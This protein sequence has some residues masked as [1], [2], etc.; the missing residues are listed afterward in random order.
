MLGILGLG[1]GMLARAGAGTGDGSGLQ[2]KRLDLVL[3]HERALCLGPAWVDATSRKICEHPPEK[4]E[5]QRGPWPVQ[6]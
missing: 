1:L 5:A 2:A 3:Q 4:G 6:S